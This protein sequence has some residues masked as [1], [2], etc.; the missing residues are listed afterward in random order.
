MKKIL[1]IIVA[2]ITMLS[3]MSCTKEEVNVL[4]DYPPMV[5]WNDQNYM[6]QDRTLN[7]SEDDLVV[8]GKIL[9]VLDPSDK[10]TENASSNEFEV[11]AILY[12]LLVMMSMR[13]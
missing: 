13:R 8:I 9:K 3:F 10:L 5:Y 12:T 6:I 11:G 1:L 4:S 7:V 2:I